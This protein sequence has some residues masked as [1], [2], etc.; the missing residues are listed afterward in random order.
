MPRIQTYISVSVPD[1]ETIYDFI[2]KIRV[3]AKTEL[4]LSPTDNMIIEIKEG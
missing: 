4:H 3:F 1:S 2:K